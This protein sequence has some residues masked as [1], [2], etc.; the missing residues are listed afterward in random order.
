MSDA[1]SIFLFSISSQISSS[2]V[3]VLTGQQILDKDPP[4]HFA[5]LRLQL[6]ELIRSC[7]G[8]DIKPALDFASEQLGPR[9]P[10]SPEFLNDLEQTMSL[11]FFPVDKLPPQLK[12][13]LEPDL[14]REVAEKV[15]KAVLYHQSRRR[16]AAIR[17][18]VRMRAWAENAA[19]ESKKDLPDRIELGF[20]GDDN[21]SLGDRLHENGHEPM[22]T[23]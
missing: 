23:T 10:T 5:L 7:N 13:L 12:A 22:I 14:R 21:D 9:A 20:N 8:D 16:E 11:L 15:N 1:L 6:V 18:L 4:L 17:Q 3:A 19:R 2:T